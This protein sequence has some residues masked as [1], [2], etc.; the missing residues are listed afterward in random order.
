[1]RHFE[2]EP[3]RGVGEPEEPSEPPQGEDQPWYDRMEQP[4]GDEQYEYEPDFD[5]GDSDE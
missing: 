5:Y 3:C 2:D 1:M 4:V